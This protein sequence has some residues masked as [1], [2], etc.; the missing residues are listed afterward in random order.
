MIP[1]NSK[2]VFNSP[3]LRDSS[4]GSMN[5]RKLI[6]H[7]SKVVSYFRDHTSDIPHPIKFWKDIN[8]M[9]A[10]HRLLQLYYELISALMHTSYYSTKL[11]TV[12]SSYDNFLMVKALISRYR[13]SS[14][15]SCKNN[16]D[17]TEIDI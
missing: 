17:A 9:V 2:R 4:S 13:Y 14:Y 1:T 15:R 3:R 16:L 8:P 5:W 11:C 12:T 10:N 7:H 6:N